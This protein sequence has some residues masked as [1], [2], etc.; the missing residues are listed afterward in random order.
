MAAAQRVRTS[1]AHLHTAGTP[2]GLTPV[3]DR[4]QVVQGPFRL[5]NGRVRVRQATSSS[6]RY[7]R[8]GA[9]LWADLRP[10]RWGPLRH[11]SSMPAY[12]GIW[13]IG[14]VRPWLS[15]GGSW[16]IGEYSTCA[17]CA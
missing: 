15:A 2:T 9:R 6:A 3:R 12:Q 17:R 16:G 14:L 13:A 7:A 10:R 5:V 8:F 4:A 11:Q 1:A